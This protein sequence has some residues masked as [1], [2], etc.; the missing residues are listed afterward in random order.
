MWDIKPAPRCFRNVA[1]AFSRSLGRCQYGNATLLC[2]GLMTVRRS[3][4]EHRHFRVIRMIA[5]IF[6]AVMLSTHAA[7]AGIITIPDTLAARADLSLLKDCPQRAAVL[8]LLSDLSHGTATHADSRFHIHT[9]GRK[10]HPTI[11]FTLHSTGE[12]PTFPTLVYCL[13]L[14]A[15]SKESLAKNGLFSPGDDIPRGSFFYDSRLGIY[16]DPR[17]INLIPTSK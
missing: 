17:S 1:Q 9:V 3:V 5:T 6:S 13:V 12:E 15:G 2:S 4:K 7:Q 10:D 16:V 14:Y 11:A 8:A